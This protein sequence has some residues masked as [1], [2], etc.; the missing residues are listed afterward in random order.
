MSIISQNGIPT[1]CRDICRD[2]SQ[3]EIEGIRT[4]VAQIESL[5]SYPIDDDSRHQFFRTQ[6]D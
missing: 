3:G 1:L 5:E 2:I 6:T 4:P